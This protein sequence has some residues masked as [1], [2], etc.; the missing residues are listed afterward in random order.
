MGDN[1]WKDLIDSRRPYIKEM[2]MRVVMHNHSFLIIDAAPGLKT[3]FTLYREDF[4]ERG[5]GFDTTISEAAKFFA[6]IQ[7][8]YRCNGES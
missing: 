1:A 2:G 6:R 5:L 7:P 8:F 3:E 4:E